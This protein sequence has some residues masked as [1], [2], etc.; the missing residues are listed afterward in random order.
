MRQTLSRGVFAAAAATGILSLTGSPALADTEA[1]AVAQ[2]SSG[3]LSGNSVQVPVSVPVNVCGNSVGAA[4]AI[5]RAV[6]NHCGNASY[7]AEDDSSESSYGD[8]GYGYGDEDETPAPST[9]PA[10]GTPSPEPEGKT[11]RHTPPPTR[12][13]QTPPTITTVSARQPAAPQ[14]AKTGSAELLTASAAGAALIT[15]GVVLYRRSRAA[16]HR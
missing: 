8:D 15:G 2:E 13:A 5:S 7:G 9:P 14:L 6:D 1:T 11:P 10:T 16:S 3:A 12:T 4:A